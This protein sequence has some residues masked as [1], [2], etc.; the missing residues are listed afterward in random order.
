MSAHTDAPGILMRRSAP[1]PWPLD[2]GSKIGR[3]RAGQYVGR[4]NAL[5]I[6]GS[7]PAAPASLRVIAMLDIVMIALGAA[8]F[9]SSILYVLACERM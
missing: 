7:V 6:S 2:S 4:L 5:A 8:F 9:V 3:I 1:D